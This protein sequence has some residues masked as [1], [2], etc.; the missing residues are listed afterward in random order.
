MPYIISEVLIGRLIIET[1]AEELVTSTLGAL[2]DGW[3]FFPQSCK[4]KA[5]RQAMKLIQARR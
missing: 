3:G 4:L 2:V 1:A 5:V